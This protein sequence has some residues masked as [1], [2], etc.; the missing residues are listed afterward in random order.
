MGRFFRTLLICLYLCLT[1]FI[2]PNEVCAL[3]YIDINLTSSGY[4]SEQKSEIIVVNKI[5][6]SSIVTQNPNQYEITNKT[7]RNYNLGLILD[8][9]VFSGNSLLKY[10][11]FCKNNICF[12]RIVHKISPNL[13]NAIYTRAP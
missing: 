9:K 10:N 1:I 12:N 3:N 6:D 5:H 2:K 7:N 8:E 11:T 4:F 13:K